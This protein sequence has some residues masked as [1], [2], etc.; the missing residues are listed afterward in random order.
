MS[1][2]SSEQK[3]LQEE[4]AD[5]KKKLEAALSTSASERDALQSQMGTIEA[6]RKPE[7]QPVRGLGAHGEGE[8]FRA[9]EH[10]GL[11]GGGVGV[12]EEALA[13]GVREGV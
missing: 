11:L 8:P 2:A 3:R 12:D 10:E 9:G 1:S 5:L 13:A 7:G 6:G 4:V